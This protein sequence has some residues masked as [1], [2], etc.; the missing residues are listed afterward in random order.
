MKF[1]LAPVTFAAFAALSLVSIPLARAAAET[2]A[3]D[4][5]HS[6][7]I[8]R[9][10]HLNTS[11]AYGRFNDFS[12]SIT[13]DAAK[14]EASTVQLTIKTTSVD[15]GNE[16]RDKHLRSPDFLECEKFPEMSFAST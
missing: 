5:V 13:Y 9:L 10:K 7:V 1:R 2:F 11:Y 3:V 16:G 4:T 8:F 15:T 12:G 14:P 6:S